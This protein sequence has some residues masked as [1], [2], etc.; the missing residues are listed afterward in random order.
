MMY[1]MKR[2]TVFLPDDLKRALER[3]ARRRRCSEADLIREGVRQVTR[4]DDL[5]EPVL[6]LFASGD[7]KLSADVETALEGFG[8]D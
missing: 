3:T 8:E 5:P 6:P 4:D 1:G 7:P 2:T